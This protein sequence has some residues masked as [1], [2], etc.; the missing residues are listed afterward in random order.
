LR[1]PLG[2]C[3]GHIEA[4]AIAAELA[5]AVGGR[6]GQHHHLFLS[7]LAAEAAVVAEHTPT[8]IGTLA[9]AHGL[10]QLQQCR[11][12]AWHVAPPGCE[13]IYGCL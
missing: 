3:E 10:Q 12:P 4:S 5:A 8:H 7:T 2:A 13:T 9:G 11:T 6:G 1:A